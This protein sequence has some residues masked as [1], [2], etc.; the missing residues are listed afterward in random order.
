MDPRGEKED[1]DAADESVSLLGGGKD[2][3]STAPPS[4]ATNSSTQEVMAIWKLA[5]PLAISFCFSMAQ[6]Q[7]NAVFVGHLGPVHLGA[8]TLG[9]MWTNISGFSIVWGGMTALDTLGSQA[10]G[11]GMYARVGVLAQRGLA[12]ST[13]MTV[14]VAAVW[15]WA[16][17]PILVLIGI[18]PE[19]VGLAVSFTRWYILALWPQIA[20]WIV[21]KF[22][23][24]QNIVKPQTIV[25]GVAAPFNA[26]LTYWMVY[27]TPLGF[28]GSPIAQAISSWLQLLLFLI[29]VRCRGLHKK[30]WHG[31]TTEA[32]RDWKPMV[33][34]G[35][36][37]TLQTMGGWWSWELNN[38]MAGTMG[39]VPLA[40]HA[41]MLNMAML[42]FPG[43]DGLGTA[44]TIRVGNSLGAGHGVGSLRSART[45]LVLV[46][47]LL[48]F[49]LVGIWSGR[50]RLAYLYTADESVA[51]LTAMTVPY[52]M[53]WSLSDTTSFI[54]S[55]VLRGAGKQPVGAAI[56]LASSYC[57]GVPAA[58]MLCL[59]TSLG[60][61]GL[62][63]GMGLGQG[64]ALCLQ[65]YYLLCRLDWQHAADEARRRA[66]ESTKS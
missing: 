46:W 36:S 15:W 33:M 66:Q 19:I 18:E 35:A 47:L 54:G 21:N 59:H 7:L 32:L 58:F 14:P 34:L 63:L 53:L 6:Q 50:D 29:V 11:A 28:I 23:S 52:Y 26:A 9:I 25:Q 17:G 44:I 64:V 16:T 30:C 40:S 3:P 10:Y 39:S 22:L 57:A 56:S 24:M 48:S 62:W 1:D 8:A 42:T 49:L 65:G 4:P 60:I 37:G 27:R 41:C 43:L 45:G 13:V 12:I 51:A 38:A 61:K 31:W 2:T 20:C 55:C 5:W